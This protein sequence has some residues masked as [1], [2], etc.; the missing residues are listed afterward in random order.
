MAFSSVWPERRQD[1]F[2][3]DL[4]MDTTVAVAS[5]S[6]HEAQ[7]VW[8]PN[9]DAILYLNCDSVNGCRLML[10]DPDGVRHQPVF[11]DAVP[12]FMTP[13]DANWAPADTFVV[14]AAHNETTLLP[15][16]YRANTDGSELDQLTSTGT[17]HRSPRVSP[18]GHKIA[19]IRDADVDTLES[20]DIFVME[21]DGTGEVNVTR[22]RVPFQSSL[23]WLPTGNWIAFAGEERRFG[24]ADI[25]LVRTDGTELMN[26][27]HTGALNELLPAIRSQAVP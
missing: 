15:Q 19:F 4:A 18:N 24:P 21:T 20:S 2:I 27:T 25:Y 9:G 16:I 12:G 17:P 6:S 11:R 22:G 14:F 10:T 26:L 8:S 13:F 3:S 23:T 1:I 7:P 5:G